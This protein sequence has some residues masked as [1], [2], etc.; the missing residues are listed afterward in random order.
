MVSFLQGLFSKRKPG[1]GIELATERIN[2]VEL[3]KKGQQLQLVTLAT[4]PVPE[5]IVQDGQIVDTLAMAELIQAAITDNNIKAKTV[6]TSIPGREAVTRIIPVPA[7]LS[8]DELKDYMNSEAGLYL[9]FPREEADVDYQKLGRFVDEDGIEKIQVLLVATR[10]EVTNSYVETFAQAGLKVTVLE[11]SNFSLIRTLKNQLEQ[12]SS[13]E[14]AIIADLEFD[15]TELAIVV[16]G[17]PQFNRTIPIG[18]YQ[19]QSTLNSAMN[20]PPTRD[21]SELLAMTLPMTDTIGALSDPNPGTNAI[22]KVFTEL[23]DELR[24]S[25]DFYINQSDGLE[26]AQLLLTGPGAAIGQL[27]EFFM[28]RLAMPATQVDPIES[29]SIAFEREIPPEQRASLG[30]VLGLGMRMI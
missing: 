17:I 12:F 30:V 15:S 4:I 22:I 20:L 14:A 6:G 13:N 3:R 2:L 25:V 11:V 24:R 7:D 16:D 10:K 27:D 18:L 8:D 9:P 23:A 28:Q 26:M 29:L 1:V 19:I 21:V 5:G